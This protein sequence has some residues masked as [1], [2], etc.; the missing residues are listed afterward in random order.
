MVTVDDTV[1]PFRTTL[2]PVEVMLEPTEPPVIFK[3]APLATVTLL[4]MVVAARVQVAPA[5]TMTLPLMLPPDDVPLHDVLVLLL[6]VKVS[7]AVALAPPTS[8]IVTVTV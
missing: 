6:T 1:V 7:V 4:V 3:V 2:P 8:F 5:A